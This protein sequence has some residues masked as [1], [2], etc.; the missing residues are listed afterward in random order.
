MDFDETNNEELEAELYSRIHH[1]QPDSTEAVVEQPVQ[2]NR[3]VSKH[4][5][6][7][8]SKAPKKNPTKN[9]KK[10]VNMNPNPFAIASALTKQ[11]P[12]RLT[13]Y[14]SYLSQVDSKPI[15]NEKSAID[16]KVNEQRPNP[17][18]KGFNRAEAKKHRIQLMQA[19][20]ARANLVREAIQHRKEETE[21]SVP[22]KNEIENTIAIPDSDSDDDV[23]IYPP[24]EPTVIS[25]DD[26]SDNEIKSPDP[27]NEL[28]DDC[29]EIN[30]DYDKR[31]SRHE[32]PFGGIDVDELNTIVGGISNRQS[33]V[34]EKSDTF[35]NFVQPLRADRQSTKRSYDVSETDFAATDV[36]E[37]ESSDLAE[38][39]VTKGKNLTTVLSESDD[40]VIDT[41][42]RSKRMR[43]RK[44]SGSNRGSDCIS[45]DDSD[46]DLGAYLEPEKTSRPY[47]LHR[48][49]GVFNAVTKYSKRQT[50]ISRSTALND[51]VSSDD[52][53]TNETEEPENNQAK[54]KETWIVTDE[55]GE[56]DVVDIDLQKDDCTEISESKSNGDKD[57]DNSV[58]SERLVVH[59]EMGW[60]DE[61]KAFYNDSWGGETHNSHALRKQMPRESYNWHLDAKDLRS[62]FNV[63]KSIKC[64]NCHENGHRM[65]F[66]PQPKREVVCYTCG[67]G[68]HR[69]SRC[70]NSICLRCGEKTNSYR[71]GCERCH[72][73]TNVECRKCNRRGHYARLCP[74]NWRAYHNTTDTT[75]APVR[76]PIIKSN[77][78]RYCSVC[79]RPGHR[80]EQ[81]YD[82]KLLLQDE[83][84]PSFVKNYEKV[85][86][87]EQIDNSMA[88]PYSMFENPRKDFRFKWNVNES[89]D[90]VYGR[91]LEAVNIR[92]ND[93]KR[94][95]RMKVKPLSLTEK[96]VLNPMNAHYIR[97]KPKKQF[98]KNFYEEPSQ[99][100]SEEPS[101]QISQ[102]VS[103]PLS[104]PPCQ[105]SNVEDITE[106]SEIVAEH[107][108]IGNIREE[109]NAI[110]N[111]DDRDDVEMK[112]ID[113][114][115]DTSSPVDEQKCEESIV[116]QIGEDKVVTESMKVD[117]I[118][119]KSFS[120]LNFSFT[121]Q[122]DSLGN[123]KPAFDLSFI[124]NS[125]GDQQ[126]K[127]VA[128]I[129][130]SSARKL[131]NE[132]EIQRLTEMEISLHKLKDRI[133]KTMPPNDIVLN[134]STTNDQSVHAIHDSDSNYS[135]GE[136]FNESK[137]KD[138]ECQSDA[139][140]LPDF[141]PL[142]PHIDAKD[143]AE[144]SE[145]VESENR[146]A[147]AVTSAKIFLTKQHARLLL[148][149]EAGN[150]LLS[151]ASVTHNVKVRMDWENLG[152][153]LVVVGSTANQNRFHA[154]LIRFLVDLC[155][156]MRIKNETFQQLPRSKVALIRF[157]REQFALL[158][159]PLGNVHELYK[160]MIRNENLKSKNGTKNA[161]RARKSLNIILMG[162]A[163]LR[164]G[165][166]HLAGLESNLKFL[167]ENNKDMMTKH[168]RAEIYQ[169][170][171]Y[172]FSPYEHDDYPDLIAQF[173]EMKRE[174]RF[175]P[176][177]IN[178]NLMEMKICVGN[179]ENEELS[180]A[181][182][183]LLR[184]SDSE[185]PTKTIDVENEVSTLDVVPEPS[186]PT[187]DVKAS[188][189][190]RTPK[191]EPKSA[192]AESKVQT[193]NEENV[194]L[195]AKSSVD[196]S[197]SPHKNAV[198]SLKCKD[199]VEQC[200]QKHIKST[201]IMDKLNTVLEKA[202]R[203]QLSYADYKNLE[204][205]L[206]N[207]NE[208]V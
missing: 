31:L 167:L 201:K 194:D 177:N 14:T 84:V 74:D 133:H 124:S 169:H 9:G 121:E 94:K 93:V 6:V 27:P 148:S 208:S 96:L 69:E 26:D 103:P 89:S 13:P 160:N 47:Y 141:I 23:Y 175:V 3:V 11:I 156:K 87:D 127:D 66:C 134:I 91:F 112:E 77:N 130:K 4:S 17:F 115:A 101:Q 151:D 128:P 200:R 8:N 90:R 195:T 16:A 79:A 189:K 206:N 142:P 92:R 179:E 108:E 1:D 102:Q 203:N 85:Y 132:A 181:K 111:A 196:E 126:H 97:E 143:M 34:A 193:K 137:S 70:P 145:I 95:K 63:L 204:K 54:D 118:A 19:K 68:G 197:S 162:R 170:Y 28:H 43:K 166:F 32:D 120:S 99:P 172:V 81:C 88:T 50:S 42:K 107:V 182:Q 15:E 44:S 202:S 2:Y 192:K 64:H 144:A 58:R 116:E 38:M 159:Q 100:I 114:I 41:T 184:V 174:K 98:S 173:E 53:P 187:R 183:K 56:T 72:H 60:N 106:T 129:S 131:R 117:K 152:N 161:D 198:W 186:T 155:K 10:D 21:V 49:E 135:F 165:R 75:S 86:P 163:G 35:A 178:R 36:Y 180:R 39:N 45:S 164:D 109:S 46:N 51:I 71:R 104:D 168:T 123:D 191:L 190:I 153:V 140:D 59:P 57:D 61:M 78:K 73:M 110:A 62:N 125:D 157:I 82:F 65:A 188:S 136:Y 119:D 30:V 185:S 40:S 48:G 55:V 29:D 113:D 146:A 105:Q 37:S 138:K 154:D 33:S 18:N 176:V 199:I 20:K 171:R 158:E 80:A 52:S 67:V 122:L 5:V 83:P 207:L 139:T 76:A 24:E 22:S 12:K 150:Q 7:N 149:T 25:S 147:K 205:I